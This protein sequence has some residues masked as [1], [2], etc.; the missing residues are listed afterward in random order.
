MSC[1]LS[2]EFHLPVS[3]ARVLDLLLDPVLIRKWSGGAVEIDKSVGGAV[4]M[5]DG[6]VTG[7]ITKMGNNELAYTWRLRDWKEEVKSSEVHYRLVKEKDGTMVVVTH[8]NLPDE[9]E[10]AYHATN[11]DEQFFGPMEEYLWATMKK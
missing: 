3:P 4:S 1:N 7:T 9:E 6:F 11:W 10:A 2:L 8:T 5:F